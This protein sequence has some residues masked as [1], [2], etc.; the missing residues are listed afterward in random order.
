MNGRLCAIATRIIATTAFLCPC[1]LARPAETGAGHDSAGGRP[2]GSGMLRYCTLLGP[3]SD[4]VFYARY[5]GIGV[6]KDA[7]DVFLS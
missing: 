7:S 2:R 1:P 6:D 3:R 5:V 4:K